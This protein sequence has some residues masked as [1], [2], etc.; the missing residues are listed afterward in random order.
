MSKKRKSAALRYYYRHRKQI[1]ERRKDTP[2]KRSRLAANTRRH[3]ANLKLEV[4]THYGPSGQLCCSWL[5][6]HVSDVDML[7]LDHLDDSG[8]RHRQDK[9]DS[10]RVGVGWYRKLKQSGFP[11]GFQTLCFNHQ[12][13]KQITKLRSL[14]V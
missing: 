10:S 8:A 2:E 12:W 4:L 1:L 14:H 9:S 5:D 13:K 3:N 7:S 11:V 6:C